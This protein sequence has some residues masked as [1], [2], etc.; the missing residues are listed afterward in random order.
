MD[1][2]HRRPQVSETRNGHDCGFCAELDPNFGKRRPVDKLVHNKDHATAAGHLSEDGYVKH[3]MLEISVKL[4]P[5][6]SPPKIN[7]A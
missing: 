7:A 6:N 5:A 3:R 4:R 2:M 1:F